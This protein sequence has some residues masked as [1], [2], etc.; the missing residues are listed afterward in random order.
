MEYLSSGGKLKH[1]HALFDR[2]DKISFASED[3]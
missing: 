1:H 2:V 3:F